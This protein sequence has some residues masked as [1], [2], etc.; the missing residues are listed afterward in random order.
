M[1]R[2][3]LDQWETIRAE[4]EVGASFGDL[5]LKHGVDKA[6][7]VRRAKKEKWT[8]PVRTI[9]PKPVTQK[10]SAEEIA[11]LRAEVE[12][13]DAERE[14]QKA[15]K[16]KRKA[17]A[18]KV[19]AFEQAIKKGGLVY[20]VYCEHAGERWH[21]IGVAA[22]FTARLA[23]IQTGCPLPVKP[24]LFGWVN[25]ARFVEKELHAEFESYRVSGEWFSLPDAQIGKAVRLLSDEIVKSATTELELVCQG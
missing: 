4:R 7:I 22:D 20:I 9:T 21:K 10:T 5:A 24:L 23:V 16:E 19:V 2:L 18:K 13:R 6:A 17:D 14:R 8:V 1:P 3:K 15:E 12:R 11:I 25:A